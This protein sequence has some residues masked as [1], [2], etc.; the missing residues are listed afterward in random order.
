M[1]V[2]ARRGHQYRNA[3]DQLQAREV[4]F[5]CLETPLV[6]AGLAAGLAALFGAVANKL[7][8]GLAEP[9]QASAIVR[10]DADTGG[11]REVAGT[12]ANRCRCKALVE[13]SFRKP[14]RTAVMA[15]VME[16]S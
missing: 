15:T 4:Q 9:L 7:A 16:L 14:S 3:V 12:G 6:A 2:R 5:G 1:V 10:M 8:T 11:H 13:L